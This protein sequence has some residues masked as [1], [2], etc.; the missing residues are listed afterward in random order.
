MSQEP[1]DPVRPTLV[2]FPA[3][4]VPECG[5]DLYY[6][7]DAFPLM[8]TISTVLKGSGDCA[9]VQWRFLGFSMAEWTLLIFL[10]MF[11]VAVLMLFKGGH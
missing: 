1:C 4:Q 6:M 11:V 7:L 10:V 2:A 3:D 8:K 9:E 5:P